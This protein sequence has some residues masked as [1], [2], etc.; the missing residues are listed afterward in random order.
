MNTIILNDGQQHANHWQKNLVSTENIFILSHKSKFLVKTGQM[1]EKT[2]IHH[3]SNIFTAI[4][5]NFIVEKATNY[6]IFCEKCCTENLDCLPRICL[7]CMNAPEYSLQKLS[8]LLDKN[9]KTFIP[10]FVN[11][12][13]WLFFYSFRFKSINVKICYLN[14]I[15]LHFLHWNASFFELIYTLK[16]GNF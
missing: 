5:H 8:S 3:L 14:Q 11:I 12:N 4:L 16:K 1:M 6:H 15:C 9:F 7:Q 2:I 10:L 13:Y